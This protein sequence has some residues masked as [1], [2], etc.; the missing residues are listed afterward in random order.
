MKT[1]AVTLVLGASLKPERYSYM[2]ILNLRRHD[3]PVIAVGLREGHV[4]D[5]PVVKDI[6]KGTAVHTVTLYLNAHNQEPWEERIL[7]LK[8]KRIIFN[9][10]AENSVFERKAKA[11]GVEV[12]EACT[13]VML[14]TGQY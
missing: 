11:A 14:N 10:G 9:P 7:A 1:E 4:A 13:L 3:Q 12:L 6:P 2:A 5:V 8:P